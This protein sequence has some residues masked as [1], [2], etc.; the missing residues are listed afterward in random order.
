MRNIVPEISSL[1]Q[2]REAQKNPELFRPSRCPYCDKAGLHC[3]GCYYRKADRGNALTHILVII[4]RFL[5]PTC[6]KTCSVLPV[7]QSF[8]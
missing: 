1:N 5:C 3:H 2:Y 4:F 7:M 6:N 8:A